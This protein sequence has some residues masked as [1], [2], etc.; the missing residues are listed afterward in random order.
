[1]L[2]GQSLVEHQLLRAA[3]KLVDA[4][5]RVA[6]VRAYECLVRLMRSQINAEALAAA[7]RGQATTK[8]A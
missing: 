3:R 1:M 5:G 4:H 7:E 2:S 6:R 8:A